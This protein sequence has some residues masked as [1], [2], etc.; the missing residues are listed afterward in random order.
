[1]K[2][3][4]VLLAAAVALGGASLAEGHNATTHYSSCAAIWRVY[5]YGIG[6]EGAPGHARTPFHVSDSLYAA[7]RHLDGNDDGIACN[8]K[9]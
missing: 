9:S 3:W 2:T 4:S 8:A 7:N 1:M 6:R 5:P